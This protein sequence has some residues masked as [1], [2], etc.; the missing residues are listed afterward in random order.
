MTKKINKSGLRIDTMVMFI[1]VCVTLIQACCIRVSADH[2]VPFYG[3]GDG[4][5]PLNKPP[6]EHRENGKDH[7][8]QTKD[9]NVS[10]LHFR[11]DTQ[12]V[13]PLK[14]THPGYELQYDSSTRIQASTNTMDSMTSHSQI[15]QDSPL[16][17]CDELRL[18]PHYRESLN[19]FLMRYHTLDIFQKRIRPSVISEH[20]NDHRRRLQEDTPP[21]PLWQAIFVTIVL[22]LMFIALLSDRIGADW[23]MITALTVCMVSGI[24]TIPEGLAGFSNEGVM[25]VVVLFVVAAGI[26]HTGALDWYMS[27]LLG[28]PR[29]IADAQV[30]I[31]IPMAAV[32]AFLNNTPVVVIMIPIVQRWGKTCGISAKQLL[33][34][35]SF[36]SILGGTCTLIG[37]STNLVVY[38]LLQED[39][40]D[41][42]AQISIFSLGEYGI[43]IAFVGG[44]YILLFS[45]W[46]IPGGLLCNGKGDDGGGGAFPSSSGDQ[47]VL[48]GARLTKWSAAAGR[49]VKRSGLRDTGGIY[50]VSVY[51]VATGN[52][53]RAVG[54]DFVVN[55]G[56]VLYFTGLVEEFGAFCDEHGLEIVT[57][58]VEQELVD[59]A[60]ATRDNSGASEN[61]SSIVDA[62]GSPTGSPLNSPF[63]SLVM[64]QGPV[65]NTAANGT[66]G[67]IAESVTFEITDVPVPDFA[68]IPKPVVGIT[69]RSISTATTA[70][71]LRLINHMTDLI[72]GRVDHDNR[73]CD[74][75][76]DGAGGTILKGVDPPQIIVVTD[77]SP[78]M[79]TE[80]ILIGVNCVDRSGLL[81]D[82]SRGITGLSLQCRHT[83]AAVVGLRSVS[84][85]RCEVQKKGFQD[86]EHIWS[87][88]KALLENETG[89]QAVKE[90]GISVIRAVVTKYSRLIGKT[91]PELDFRGTYKAAIV[92]VKRGGKNMSQGLSTIR[93][94]AGD[95]LVLQASNDSGLLKRPS[96]DFY[97]KLAEGEGISS[98]KKVSSVQDLVSLMRGKPSSQHESLRNG[99]A[100]ESTTNG[101]KDVENGIGSAAPLDTSEGSD[102]SRYTAEDR[103]FEVCDHFH[104]CLWALLLIVFVLS[105]RHPGLL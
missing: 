105:L 86:I 79:G 87:V 40:P 89:I 90:R 26:A 35:L 13:I 47:E 17:M 42:A 82:I 38:G 14:R 37:T 45:Q 72:N 69:K 81:F 20:N 104:R 27:K 92:A 59:E 71:R 50:L 77:F 67:P 83:E 51:R 23:V 41:V 29:N 57:N 39:Y 12:Q 4:D 16:V 36:A 19:L 5:T 102:F 11:A 21:P 103:E 30:R 91:A 76:G 70:L 32:S 98:P 63:G 1:V 95:L 93:F 73:L 88:L 31:M 97:K 99:G 18:G 22:F 62:I 25:T 96:D 65:G 80:L 43:P 28:K 75:V 58:E 60:A 3:N 64:D 78:A 6:S 7:V 33:I 74:G 15:L 10:Q 48:L 24:I 56:D 44:V 9:F 53:H 101:N 94:E 66:L 49:T 52:V 55:A 61:A 85:W 100:D 84:V 68:S 46:L 54:Q 2:L 34:P 8:P